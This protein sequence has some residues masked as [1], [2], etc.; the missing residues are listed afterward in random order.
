MNIHLIGILNITPDSF[1]DGGVYTS[2][3]LQKKK[4]EDL[5]KDGSDIIEIGGDSTRPGSQCTGPE[6]EWKRIEGILTYV[7]ESGLNLKISIDTHH[8]QTVEK[9]ILK[10]INFFNIVT[11]NNIEESNIKH[12]FNLISGTK[13]KLSI[14]HNSRGKVHQFL[15]RQKVDTS[16]SDII[17]QKNQFF[18]NLLNIS[19]KF[20]INPQNLIFDPGW[21]AFLDSDPEVTFNLIRRIEKMDLLTNTFMIGVSRKGFLSYQGNSPIEREYISSYVV[22]EILRKLKAEQVYVRSHNIKVLREFLHI[23]NKICPSI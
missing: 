12:I 7:N 4:F 20:D 3:D 19:Q 22:I 15:D 11:D 21:G 10:G 18:A 16:T 13:I 1:S 14:M 17:T 8:I 23:Y 2:L 9:G 6:E 5:I